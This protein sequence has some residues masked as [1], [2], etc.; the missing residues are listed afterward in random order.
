MEVGTT[1]YRLTNAGATV[2]EAQ[3]PEGRPISCII[4]FENDL[5]F[6]FIADSNYDYYKIK[7]TPRDCATPLGLQFML[8]ESEDCIP[9]TFQYKGCVNPYEVQEISMM[10][11]QFDHGKNYFI[12]VDGNNGNVCEFDL[13]LEGLMDDANSRADILRMRYDYTPDEPPYFQPPAQQIRFENN[14]VVLEWEADTREAISLFMVQRYFE[15]TFSKYGKV[16]GLIQPENTTTD[17]LASYR[18]IDNQTIFQDGK[19][20]CYRIVKVD[21]DGN[22]VYTKPICISAD[23]ITSFQ[24]TQVFPDKTKGKGHFVI[25]YTNNKKQGLTFRILDSQ[26]KELKKLELKK[27]PK[28]SSQI[29]LDMTEYPPGLY[30]LWVEGKFAHYSREFLVK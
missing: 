13:S 26:Q 20:Y 18:F 15:F 8:I 7:L 14:E 17:G 4:S 10:L 1:L 16:L 11:T 27:V 30:Y 23:L 3:T 22:R 6:R 21:P 28:E 5:W 24:V 12:Y 2:T 19:E 9:E 29:G 25:L